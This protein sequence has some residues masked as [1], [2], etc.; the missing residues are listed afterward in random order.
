LRITPMASSPGGYAP[1][2]TE[3]V[4]KAGQDPEEPRRMH[5]TRSKPR[6]K[7]WRSLA[8]MTYGCLVGVVSVVP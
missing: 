3:C 8:A 6:A 7:L 2:W 1:P 5:N 4:I